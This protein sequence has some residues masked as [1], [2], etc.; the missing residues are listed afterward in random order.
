MAISVIVQ[1]TNP[2][3][4]VNHYSIYYDTV[5]PA[6]LLETNVP[7]A[8]VQTGYIVSNIPDTASYLILL[9]DCNT[10]AFI[11]IYGVTP[12]PTPSQH[13][14]FD[15]TVNYGLTPTPTATKTA[16]PSTTPS[17]T[18]TQTRT[19]SQT[20]TQTRTPTQTPSQTVTQ[21]QTPTP[22]VTKTPTRTPIV[23]P[24]NTATPTL[25]PSHTP[26][27]SVTPSHTLT[28]SVT[29]TFTPT[30][31]VTPNFPTLYFGISTTPDIPNSATITA[32]VHSFLSPVMDN[33]LDWNSLTGVAQYC[34]FA[35]FDAGIPSLKNY[36]YVDSLNNGAIGGGDNLFSSPSTVVVDGYNYNV[37]IT[38]FKTQ[39]TTACT[40]KNTP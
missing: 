33:T 10:T 40:V 4:A 32:G 20:P 11:S 23:T 2:G 3:A 21:T 25:T 38:N 18:A 34:W 31:S 1:I 6:N 27:P 26:T 15:F 19:P 14:G 39:F 24:T 8:S 30:P 29:P 12:T 7:V 35:V 16:T 22:L 17:Q 36:W 5:T 13:C 37:Y 28:P 9:S